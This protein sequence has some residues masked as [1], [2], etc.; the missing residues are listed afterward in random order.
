MKKEFLELRRRLR[1]PPRLEE[2][3][4]ERQINLLSNIVLIY[5]EAML[6]KNGQ[7]MHELVTTFDEDGN[8]YLSHDEFKD[9]IDQLDDIELTNEQ[10]R[11]VIRQLDEDNDGMVSLAELEHQ[12]RYHFHRRLCGP[13]CVVMIT[14]IY[15]SFVRHEHRCTR[16]GLHPR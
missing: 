10:F 5:I 3:E 16:V 8:G 2:A 13:V 4:R 15:D 9:I 14:L 12:V 11:D 1:Q 6:F 7:L